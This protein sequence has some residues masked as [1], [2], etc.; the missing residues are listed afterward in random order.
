MR[1]LLQAPEPSLPA[2]AG[3]VAVVIAV[4]AA[5]I[6]LVGVAAGRDGH[7][8]LESGRPSGLQRRFT[9]AILAW[10]A[11]TG[12]LAASGVLSHFEVRPPPMMPL[13]L[14]SF[15][16]TTVLGLSRFGAMLARG[17]P[18]AALIGLQAFRAPLELILYQLSLDGVLPVQMTFDGM[19]KD[20]ATGIVAALL[21][22]WACFA[23]P[24]RILVRLWNLMGVVLLAIIVTIAITSMPGPLRVFP[25]DPPNTIVATFPFV[26]IPTVLVQAAWLGHLLV[27]RRLR[28]AR[29][30]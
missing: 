18:L 26:W 8:T 22:I 19:N 20:I 28:L 25:N 29:R 17:I 5:M 3:L 15:A 30:S 12:A 1:S 2:V 7:D 4:V 16:L 11:A 13:A 21:G 14:I 6:A 27:F 23:E 24:P 10:L 9:V